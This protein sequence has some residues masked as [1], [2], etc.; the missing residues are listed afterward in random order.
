MEFR[1]VYEGPLRANGAA[2]EKQTLRRHFHPQLQRLW[3]QQPLKEH[4]ADSVHSIPTARPPP[5]ERPGLLHAVRGFDFVP[6][7]TTRWHLVTELDVLFLRPQPPGSL[8][9]HGGD[10][11]TRMKTLLDALQMPHPNQVSNEDRPAEAER[12]FFCLLE[13]DALVTKLSVT[14]DQLLMPPDDT[15]V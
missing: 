4:E 1:L 7:V 9:V 10:I 2:S 5:G 14:T 13:N 6:L 15:R 11:D 8:I 3:N 12:P